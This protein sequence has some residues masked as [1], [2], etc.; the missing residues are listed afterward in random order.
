MQAIVRDHYG[1]PDVLALRD[2]DQ[3]V[4]TDDQ[5]LVRVRAVSVNPRDWHLMR[6]MP[7]FVRAVG[8]GLRAPVHRGLGSD[9]AGQ[10]EAVGKNVTRFRPGDE[11][12]GDIATGGLAECVA[13]APD[14][15]S[16]K[17]AN[18][19]FE[20]A[21]AVPLAA[22]TALQGLRDCGR[23][24]PGQKVLIVGA[25]GGVGTFAVQIARALGAEVT[26]V[27]STRNVELVR[28]LGA[29]GVIDYTVQ[30]FTRA[31]QQYDLI[32]Q[33]AG[34]SS[35][36]DCRR[37]L[38][39]HGTVVLSSGDSPNRWIGP[40]G[41]ILAGVAL[42]RFVSQRIVVLDTKSRAQD[43]QCLTELIE[44]GKVTPVIDRT[45]PLKDAAEAIRYLETGHVRGKVVVSVSIS[46]SV[47]RT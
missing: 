30:D 15:L 27:C 9:I 33:L 21:A 18:L 11:V 19:T 38:T 8:Y 22:L 40:I 44:A 12:Y 28:S 3:P 46:G 16:P 1:S 23:L 43:L 14:L 24:Q 37:A 10:V 25:A 39:A 31:G 7:Y 13:V 26:G 32:L 17:P 47:D 45:Y 35:A 5:V 20:Q 36:A 6:G 4:V 34:T 42:S 2:V 41:R 29:E